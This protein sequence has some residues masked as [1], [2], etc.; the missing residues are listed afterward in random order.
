MALFETLMWLCLESSA[1]DDTHRRYTQS[2]QFCL[3]TD[4]CRRRELPVEETTAWKQESR[5]VH[6]SK[7][8]G[9]KKLG[10][11][12]LGEI[13]RHSDITAYYKSRRTK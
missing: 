13:S 12:D 7:Y 11:P 8:M 6:Y 9:H 10:L 4:S 3:F 1:G 2:C 5:L